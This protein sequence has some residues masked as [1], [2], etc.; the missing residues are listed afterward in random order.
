MPT[1]LAYFGYPLDAGSDGLGKPPELTDLLP[2]YGQDQYHRANQKAQR[3]TQLTPM[4]SGDLF[5]AQR[6]KERPVDGRQAGNEL[7]RL[8]TKQVHPFTPAALPKADVR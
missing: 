2:V 4:L 1:P 7:E 8:V 6:R 3:T 5:G